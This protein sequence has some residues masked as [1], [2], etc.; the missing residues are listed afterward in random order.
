MEKIKI[1]MVDD[2]VEFIT[3][4]SERIQLRGLD[5][6][7][8]FDGKSALEML[9]CQQFD[10]MILDLKMPGLSGMEVLKK[11]TE[12]FPEMPVIILTAHGSEKDEKGA[13]HLGAFEYLNKP[14]DID[15]F[16]HHI[17]HAHNS[18]ML[19]TRFRP[20]VTTKH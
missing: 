12:A 16:I 3:T 13:R 19:I 17:H 15:T 11:T 14:V 5:C 18:K 8:A 9:R 1:L 4:L 6:K 10:V 20:N 7:T 2:E